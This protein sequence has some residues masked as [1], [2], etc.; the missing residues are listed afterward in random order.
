MAQ[1]DVHL[2]RQALGNSHAGEAWQS[3][4]QRAELVMK[5]ILFDLPSFKLRTRQN[6]YCAKE[7][8]LLDYVLGKL[9]LKNN[10]VFF[11]LEVTALAHLRK[12]TWVYVACK[13]WNDFGKKSCS[14]SSVLSSKCA[15]VLNLAFCFP[16]I[17]LLAVAAG[18]LIFF[19]LH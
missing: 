2:N 8:K 16:K 4:D 17:F 13:I 18:L 15:M 12:W 19:K 5:S 10:G 11:Q 6:V 7:N 9:G 3:S 14:L 1:S